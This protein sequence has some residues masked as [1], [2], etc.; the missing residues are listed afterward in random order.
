M[1]IIPSTQLTCTVT[2]TLADLTQGAQSTLV[3]NRLNNPIVFKAQQIIYEGYLNLPINSSTGTISPTPGT[4]TFSALYV[5]NGGGT[6]VILSYTLSNL[7]AQSMYLDSGAL[8]FWQTP[9]QTSTNIGVSFV[10]G[11][12]NFS[13]ASGTTLPATNIEILA[14]A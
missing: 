14:A 7:T 5:R 12:A 9:Q 11:L 13:I 1:A 2:L 8:F 10:S 3:L 4:P 6:P